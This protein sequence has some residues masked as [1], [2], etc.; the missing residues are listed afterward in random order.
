VAV[1]AFIGPKAAATKRDSK[2]HNRCVRNL[3]GEQQKLVQLH[4]K[5]LID[6]ETLAPEQQRIATERAISRRLAAEA[7]YQAAEVFG[8]LDI[9]L[10]LAAENVLWDDLTPNARG[11]TTQTIFEKLIPF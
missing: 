7:S 5:G 1:E 10:K 2:R 4:Y 9:A 8:A 3:L 11:L 6:E